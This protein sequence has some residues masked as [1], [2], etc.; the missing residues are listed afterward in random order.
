[1]LLESSINKFMVRVFQ[2]MD[3]KQ[4]K[5]AKINSKSYRDFQSIIKLGS[6][7]F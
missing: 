2:E 3:K 1:M 4:A 5:I 7:S 6:S